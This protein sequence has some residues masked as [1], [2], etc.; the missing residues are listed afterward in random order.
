MQHMPRRQGLDRPPC[1]YVAGGQWPNAPLVEGAPEPVVVVR[2][3]VRR[4]TEAMADRSVPDLAAAAGVHH[5]TLYALIAGE[6]VPDAAT[7]AKLERELGVDLWPR[8]GERRDV[9]DV[10]DAGA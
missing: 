4:L 7:V 5:R 1:E 2:L 10:K 3:L 8:L 9:R 6:R